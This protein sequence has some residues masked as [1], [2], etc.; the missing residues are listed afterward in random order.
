MSGPRKGLWTAPNQAWH[1]TIYIYD[2]PTPSFSSAELLARGA[3]LS[4]LEGV[5][6]VQEYKMRLSPRELEGLLIH[7]TGFLA[8]KRLARGLKL[9][10]P[11]AVAL[12][13]SQVKSSAH[14]CE[15]MH[16]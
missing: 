11:E 13:A 14:Q 5:N 9:N 10:L 7:Q 8:Q 3:R 4:R 15:R 1:I 2:V 16:V 12:I 6:S